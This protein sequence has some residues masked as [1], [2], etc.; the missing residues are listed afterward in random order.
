[1]ALVNVRVASGTGAA[2]PWSFDLVEDDVT[3]VVSAI[4]VVN[5]GANMLTLTAT[6]G[7]R[8]FTRSSTVQGTFAVP[9]NQRPTDDRFNAD[10]TRNFS[11][12]FRI[13]VACG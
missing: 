12:V 9:V 11:A 5:P 2:G 4:V 8:T 3:H 10:G 7:A 6:N 13:D 1:M